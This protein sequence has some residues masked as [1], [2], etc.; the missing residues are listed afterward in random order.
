MFAI[1]VTKKGRDSVAGAAGRARRSRGRVLH[2]VSKYLTVA[3]RELMV[4]FR[5]WIELRRKSRTNIR[6]LLSKVSCSVGGKNKFGQSQATSL[7]RPRV[8][9][10]VFGLAVVAQAA[11]GPT[12][13]LLLFQQVL[14]TALMSHVPLLTLVKKRNLA[15]RPC[16]FR[17][18]RTQKARYTVSRR[19]R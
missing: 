5:T 18:T 12:S 6:P 13:I 2:N 14:P 19:G 7:G 9:P 8:K 4:L 17:S 1:I 3:G 10:S 16:G 15:H 11:L